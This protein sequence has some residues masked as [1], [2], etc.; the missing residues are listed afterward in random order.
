M[1]NSQDESNATPPTSNTVQTPSSDAIA[2]GKERAKVVLAAA[3]IEAA[4]NE[5]VPD[6][7]DS[8]EQDRERPPSRKRKRETSAQ[9][10]QTE[11]YV[12][13]E[14]LYKADL[15][16]RTHKPLLLQQKQQEVQYYQKLRPLREHNPGIVF[17]VGYEGF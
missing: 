3:S 5:E 17:G 12:T 15:A 14:Y 11:Q 4:Q 1:S 16:E 7:L 13:R 2:A 9:Q 10:I 6:K 8:R